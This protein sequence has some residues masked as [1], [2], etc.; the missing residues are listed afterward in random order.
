MVIYIDVQL[1]LALVNFAFDYLLLWATATALRLPTRRGR[2]ALGA[3]TGTLY[4]ALTTLAGWG[5]LPGYGLLRF[6]LLMITFPLFM[7]AIT[8]YPTPRFWQASGMLYLISIVAAGSGVATSQLLGSPDNPHILA[9]TL[10]SFITLLLI[11][12]LGWGV[13]RQRFLYQ[14]LYIPLDIS[15]EKERKVRVMAL[16]DTGNH[17]KDPLSSRAVL[18]VER[19]ALRDILPSS[20][21]RASEEIVKGK[22]SALIADL[23]STSWA[24]RF[25]VIPYTALG[26]A[27]GLMVGFRPQQATLWIRGKAQPADDC[28]IALCNHQLDPAGHYQALIGPELLQNDLPQLSNSSSCIPEKGECTYAATAN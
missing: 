23:T 15:F 13:I 1:L 16:Y 2:L 21:A 25:H 11:A 24:Q 12:E 6:P 3:I 18:V 17:L 26:A 28:I 8:V 22:N 27:P 7:L 10:A 19:S 14:P 20:L 4:Y 5:L 9:G